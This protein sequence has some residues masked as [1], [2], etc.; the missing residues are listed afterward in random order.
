MVDRPTALLKRESGVLTAHA[1]SMPCDTCPDWTT[2]ESGY[3]CPHDDLIPDD[4]EERE[5]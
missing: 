5:A 1:P 4:L 2:C 3:G